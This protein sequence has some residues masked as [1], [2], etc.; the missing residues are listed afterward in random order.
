M[1]KTKTNDRDQ[2]DRQF[3]DIE[4]QL[5]VIE[6]GIEEMWQERRE[7]GA[8]GA[9]DPLQWALPFGKAIPLRVDL[10]ERRMTGSQTIMALH[11]QE[12]LQ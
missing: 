6:R 9:R 7:A 11:F 3:A 1:A 8:K 4:Q 5:A 2:Y 10:R 12:G